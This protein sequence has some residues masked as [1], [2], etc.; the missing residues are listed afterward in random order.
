GG[1]RL[2]TQS[3]FAMA[4]SCVKA[5]PHCLLHLVASSS[6]VV[7]PM[8]S[9]RFSLRSYLLYLTLGAVGLFFASRNG[10][11]RLAVGFALGLAASTLTLFAALAIFYVVTSLAARLTGVE[12]V[13]ARTS[14]G[15]VVPEPPPSNG[16]LA[17]SGESS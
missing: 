16:Q 6:L 11:G 9:P 13:V 3:R 7:V 8:P 1:G 4:A 10:N 17:D 14:R 12:Q 2:G 15:G 5:R